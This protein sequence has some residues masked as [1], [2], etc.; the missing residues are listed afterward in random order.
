MKSR[1]SKKGSQSIGSGA[2]RNKSSVNLTPP[3]PNHQSAVRFLVFFAAVF[4]FVFA[5]STCENMVGL[6]N[7]VNTEKPSI[8]TEGDDSRPGAFLQ[9]HKCD[10]NCD[11]PCLL[12]GKNQIVLDVEQKFGIKEVY[13]NV[14]YYVYVIDEDGERVKVKISPQDPPGLTVKQGPVE[15]VTYKDKNGKLVEVTLDPPMEVSF[16]AYFDPEAGEIDEVTGKR[17]GEWK[18]DLPTGDWADGRIVGTVTAIDISDNAVTTTDMIYNVKNSPPQI[19]LSIPKLRGIQFDSPTL[20]SKDLTENKIYTGTDLMGTAYDDKGIGTGFP[21]IMIW[22]H[23]GNIYFDDALGL[24]DQKSVQIDMVTELP[25]KI[26]PATGL[27]SLKDGDHIDAKWGKWHTVVDTAYRPLNTDPTETVTAMQFRWPLMNLTQDGEIPAP[28]FRKELQPAA[29][30]VMIVLNDAFDN[31]NW[32]YYPNRMENTKKL[33]PD[34]LYETPAD[35]P[36]QFMTIK[37]TAATNPIL[38][39]RETPSYYNPTN[40]FVGV[41]SVEMPQEGT[42]PTALYARFSHEDDTDLI[43]DTDSVTMVA[44]SKYAGGYTI[45]MPAA[46]VQAD[47]NNTN[48]SGEKYWLVKVEGLSKDSVSVTRQPVIFDATAPT[49]NFVQPR[50]IGTTDGSTPVTSKVEVRG[51]VLDNQIVDKLYFALG[52]TEIQ[53]I[54]TASLTSSTNNTGWHDT[55]LGA[56]DSTCTSS[57]NIPAHTPLSGSHNSL[58]YAGF[59]PSSYEWDPKGILQAWT[60]TFDDIAQFCPPAGQT[61]NYYVSPNTTA[62]DNN[63]WKLPIKFKMVDKAQNVGIVDALLILDP[64]GDLPEVIF[65][66]PKEG[67]TVG[68]TVRV[69]GM[70]K[71]NEWIHS[72]EIRVFNESTSTWVV[73]NA[74]TWQKIHEK[75]CTCSLH[76]SDE[77]GSMGTPG[78][79]VNWHYNLNDKGELNPPANSLWNVKVEVRAIDAFAATP[80]N[81][82]ARP[83]KTYPLNLIFDPGMPVINMPV[84]IKGNYSDWNAANQ[85]GKE[86]MEEAYSYGSNKVSGKITLRV[87]VSDDTDLDTLRVDLEGTGNLVNYLTTTTAQNNTPFVTTITAP[88]PSGKAYRLFIPLDTAANNFRSGVYGYNGTPNI[89][90]LSMDAT[91]KTDAALRRNETFTLQI[92]NFHP[93]GNYEGLNR[94]QGTEYEIKGKAWDSEKGKTRVGG[95]ERIVVYFSKPANASDTVG[96]FITLN[97]A[98]GASGTNYVTNQSARKN[99]NG[100]APDPVTGEQHALDNIGDNPAN[101]N[102]FPVITKTYNTETLKTDWISTVN[103][104]VIAADGIGRGDNQVG[105]SGG[106]IIDWS[107]FFDSTRLGAGPFILNYVVFDTS[108]NATH[109]SKR[110]FFANNRPEITK[111]KLGTDNNDDGAVND[112]RGEIV[113]IPSTT[114]DLVGHSQWDPNFRVQN[115]RLQ[116]EI[117]TKLGSG[118]G[119]KRYQV[120]YATRAEIN[121]TTTV[122]SLTAG[123]VYTIKDHGYVEWFNYGAPDFH[124]NNLS[125]EGV[126]FVATENFTLPA[127]ASVYAYTRLTP[128]TAVGSTSTSLAGNFNT[129]TITTA[130]IRFGANATGFTVGATQQNAF[131]T[132]STTGYIPE[133][134]SVAIGADNTAD[135]GKIVWNKNDP[136][137][138]IAHVYDTVPNTTPTNLADQLA[139]VAL[140]N[141]GVTNND[142]ID[143]KVEIAQ[144]GFRHEQKTSTV[145]APTY[146]ENYAHRI[147]N[148]LTAANYNE[149]VVTNTSGKRK[150]YV[151]YRTDNGTRADTSGMVIFKGKA[152][153]NNR[154]ASITVNVGGTIAGGTTVDSIRTGVTGVTTPTLTYNAATYGSTTGLTS[155]N[156]ANTIDLMKPDTATIAWGFNAPALD[157]TGTDQFIT[158]EYGHV[159]NWSFAWDTS[160]Y[161]GQVGTEVPVTFTITDAANRSTR[162]TIYVN[163]VPY[164]SEVVTPLT[165]AYSASPS[166]FN[167]SAT[168]Y[169]PVKEN[170]IITIKG[171]NLGVNNNSNTKVKINTTDLTHN[172]ATTVAAG[173]YRIVNKNEITANVGATATSG[174]LLVTVGSTVAINNDNKNTAH[175]NQE[176]N[177]TNNN[178]LTDDRYLYIWKVGAFFSEGVGGKIPADTAG[179]GNDFPYLN[180][181]LRMDSAANWYMNFGGSSTS[182]GELWAR[183]NNEATSRVVSAQNRFR[184]TTAAYDSFGNHYTIAAN[185]TAGSTNWQFFHKQLASG[186]TWA[187]TTVPSNTAGGDRFQ[188]PRIATQ[189]TGGTARSA[190]NP[191]RVLVSYYDTLTSPNNLYIHYGLVTSNTAAALNN[192]QTVASNTTTYNGSMFT[193]VGFLS[194]GRPVIAWYDRT[195]QNL[196]LS[197]GGVPADATS[198]PT[199]PNWQTN[200]K[201]VHTGAGSHVDMVI[202]N[203]EI[204]L[205]YCDPLNGGLYYAKVPVTSGVPVVTTDTHH[206]KVDTYLSA[207][208]RIML[209]VRLQGSNY[210]PY[211]SYFHNSFDETRNSVRVAWQRTFP[212]VAGAITSEGTGTATAGSDASDRLTGK[213]EVMTVPAQNTPASGLYICNGVPTVTTVPTGSATTWF[214]LQKS[215]IV[216]YMTDT[217]YEGAALKHDIY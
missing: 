58:G 156:A 216:T 123:N 147:A 78:S 121:S 116:L 8:G 44:N 151:Q 47:L 198:V 96:T 127:G 205:A 62:A 188:I 110:I 174:A 212:Y 180:P 154:I 34:S 215:M 22:P 5:L 56:H 101:L 64:D 139:H 120:Y 106:S 129:D 82:K 161:T 206:V 184:H 146:N 45:T 55:K 150:G 33:N 70:A 98:A 202:V 80:D 107:V 50:G 6:G 141:I 217:N 94:A 155:G 172:N 145:A 72:L 213:W 20:N 91:E 12:I 31:P 75:G 69:N 40:S 214:N 204:H 39:I 160:A 49:M 179:T 159:V 41:V 18:V 89:F 65:N 181:V 112:N 190:T 138:I 2:Q 99:R 93:L 42:T 1:Y 28:E 54:P 48:F 38:R 67:A 158:T 201:I 29:Y 92:D 90:S 125:Y 84:I 133:S 102:F 177:N 173:N 83:G 15:K 185:Q 175:Y 25:V 85:S 167:R 165:K 27:P 157:T 35:N 163:I 13:M 142:T 17:K 144:I 135:E 140:I 134:S 24:A 210:V 176:P 186:G 111:I 178:N 37:I 170:D 104:I 162:S 66:A 43:K 61:S 114:G 203:D 131:N 209:N 79:A 16:P 21:K 200:A 132:A 68:G 117:E 169:Y 19:E 95:I 137:Y 149:N 166:A 60:W 52:R 4:A 46:K 207:G 128:G 168:G 119:A 187:A 126:T 115:R 164:I 87:D 199:A 76:V 194:T 81:P 191:T 10:E 136:R 3:P 23:K 130:P 183:K 182:N 193:A 192:P 148:A 189:T 7:M 124:T 109:Y 32:N 113:T 152:M 153:D 63:E 105:F 122:K 11:D 51:S 197:Y 97:G 171:F 14:S 74:S 86:Q 108:G 57:C 71:D 208:T 77:I 36:I 9:S 195:N 26:D 143:P 59:L 196:I 30:N 53:N 211:I 118:N 88:T 100:K 73:G 103:G